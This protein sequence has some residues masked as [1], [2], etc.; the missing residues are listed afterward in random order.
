MFLEE[1][2][3][4]IL[5]IS[6]FSICIISISYLSFFVSNRDVKTRIYIGALTYGTLISALETFRY[7]NISY[8]EISP[9]RAVGGILGCIT[10]FYFGYQFCI[11][12]KK[13][14]TSLTE[15][16][17]FTG[18]ISCGLGEAGRQLGSFL[19]DILFPI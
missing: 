7:R 4:S 19:G 12:I 11:L 13:D 2:T 6:F 10:G 5:A 1:K 18:A 16:P 9:S 17:G 8:F 3:V 15:S 14:D